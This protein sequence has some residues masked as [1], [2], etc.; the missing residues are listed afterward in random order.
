[1]TKSQES[2]NYS[3]WSCKLANNI[4]T[5][6]VLPVHTKYIEKA[7]YREIVQIDLLCSFFAHGK[8]QH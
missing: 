7:L 4:M 1:M 3:D 6:I 5:C 8:P 2:A